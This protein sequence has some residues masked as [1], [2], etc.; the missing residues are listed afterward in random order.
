[1][2]T[3]V[4]SLAFRKYSWAASLVVDTDMGEKRL[5]F[6]IIQHVG[7]WQWN[8]SELPREFRLQ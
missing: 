4:E 5:L 6:S 3:A 1:M 8:A 2:G 7:S